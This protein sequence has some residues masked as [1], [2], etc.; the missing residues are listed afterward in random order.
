MLLLG[1]PPPPPPSPPPPKGDYIYS[2]SSPYPI[3]SSSDQ[4][5][6]FLFLNPHT[7]QESGPRILHCTYVP[8]VST[9]MSLLHSPCLASS[10]QAYTIYIHMYIVRDDHY[11]LGYISTDDIYFD[12][13][14]CSYS[15]CRWGTG[16]SGAVLGWKSIRQKK[17][18][19]LM[20]N[21]G[22]RKSIIF[23]EKRTVP[24]N[25]GRPVIP[26][27]SCCCWSADSHSTSSKLFERRYV[28]ICRFLYVCIFKL[29]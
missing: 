27:L 8:T 5:S 2:S 11:R 12:Y 20:V 19:Y 1:C 10:V 15:A 26:P 13:F 7:V 3:L 14:I 25:I 17:Y 23:H 4:E 28:L 18:L 21:F 9:H 16:E 22:Y 6:S 29:Q 24:H